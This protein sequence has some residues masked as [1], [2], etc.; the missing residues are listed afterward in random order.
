[1]ALRYSINEF[2]E[3]ITFTVP[4]EIKPAVPYVTRVQQEV[5]TKVVAALEAGLP[6]SDAATETIQAVMRRVASSVAAAEDGADG[7]QLNSEVVHEQEAEEEQEQEAEQEEQRVSA[8]SRDDEHPRPWRAS[9]LACDPTAVPAGDAAFYPVSRFR[10]RPQHKALATL[11]RSLQMSDNA[12]RLSWCGVGDRRLKNTVVFL[13]WCEVERKPDE[14][15]HGKSRFYGVI[16]LAEAETLRWLIHHCGLVNE[17]CAFA[18]RLLSTGAA[19]D[20]SSL[21][22][23]LTTRCPAGEGGLTVA[24]ARLFFRFLDNDMFFD[25]PDLERL[26]AGALRSVPDRELRAQFFEETLRLRRRHRQQWDDTPVARLLLPPED[27]DDESADATKDASK[28]D[29][30]PKVLSAVDVNSRAAYRRMRVI[31]SR[32]DAKRAAATKRLREAAAAAAK[33]PDAAGA[34]VSAS[35]DDAALDAAQLPVPMVAAVIA[36]LLRPALAQRDVATA[37][38]HG[39]PRDPACAHGGNTLSIAWLERSLFTAPAAKPAPAESEG[40]A[41][42]P[43]TAETP[44]AAGEAPANQED[45]EQEWS[46]PMC[47]GRNPWCVERCDFCESAKPKKPKSGGPAL[48]PWPCP[49]CTFI[50]EGTSR[51]CAMCNTDSGRDVGGADAAASAAALTGHMEVPEGYWV[52]APEKGG[53][54][55]FNPNS[56]FYCEVCDR[57]RPD[58]A[59]LRF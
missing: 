45:E 15:T 53:C 2:R 26:E 41:Q 46:C 38:A 42:Q 43:Q 23:S 20:Q 44:A 56:Q 1:M 55:K 59:T 35:T 11:P 31:F 8:Y 40:A 5:Q 25:E 54:S 47:S 34:T 37:L 17:R 12:F 14:T 3:D 32:N 9:Q 4:Q 51:Y 58:L 49:T 27:D 19:M 57:S 7:G 16:T 29:A 21:L 22:G 33:V 6:L 28:A 24:D 39:Q 13:E 10:C 30:A 48:D 50:N 18:L 52:C 36:P